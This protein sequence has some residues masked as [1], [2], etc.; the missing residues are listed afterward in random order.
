MRGQQTQRRNLTQRRQSRSQQT[1]QAANSQQVHILSD[2]Q[3]VVAANKERERQN[4]QSRDNVTH[5]HAAHARDEC[6][7]LLSRQNIGGTRNSGQD[8]E[9]HTHQGEIF[10]LRLGLSRQNRHARKGQRNPHQVQL[11]ARHNRRQHQRTH[12]LNSHRNRQRNL[13]NRHIEEG[14]R[15]GQGDTEN[16]DRHPLLTGPRTNLRT[17]ERPQQ[18]RRSQQAQSHHAPRAQIAHQLLSKSR[19]ELRRNNR[20]GRVRNTQSLS[21]QGRTRS[22]GRM[23][24]RS[25]SNPY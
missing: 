1:H 13:L 24:G 2:L 10:R 15:T 25:H 3:Q 22:I 5:D 19:T 6:A 14:I 8:R 16:N 23:G 17:E 12:K 9:N 4:Q 7:H 11:A 21:R 20:A 18:D